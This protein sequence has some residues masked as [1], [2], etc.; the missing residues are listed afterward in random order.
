VSDYIQSLIELLRGGNYEDPTEKIGLLSAALKENG[1]ADSKLMV[2]LLTAQQTPLRLAALGASESRTEPEIFAAIKR[3]TS[4]SDRRVRQKIAE[5]IPNLPIEEFRSHLREF[6]RDKESV[7]RL[8]AIRSTSGIFEFI[9]LQKKALIDDPRYDVRMAAAEAL[10]EQEPGEVLLPFLTVVASDSDE[11]VQKKCAEWIEQKL[12]QGLGLEQVAI[13]DTSIPIKAERA[14]KAI[15]SDQFPKLTSYLLTRTETH[16]NPS[17]LARF[18]TDLTS[19]AEKALLPRGFCIQETTQ[20]LLKL[21]KSDSARS[22]ALLGETGTGKSAA[23]NELVYELKKAENGG[24]RVLR[25]SPSE[26]LADTKWL[27]E[28]QTKLRDLINLV[29]KPRHVLIYI[30]NISELSFIGRTS[31]DESNIAT[32]LAPYMEDGSILLLGESTPEEFQRGLGSEGSLHRLF[33]KLV[34]TEASLTQTRSILEEI[35]KETGCNISDAGLDQTLELS[36]QFFGNIRRPGSAAG[37]LRALAG[38]HQRKIRPIELRDILDAIS[39]STGL[40]TDLLDDSLPIDL[41]KVRSFFEKRVMGQPEAVDAV[42]DLVVLIKAGLTDPNKPMGVLLFAGPT[43]VGKTELARALAE[44]IFGDASRLRRFDMS[45]FA[46]REGLERLIGTSMTNG[47]L[48]DAVRQ[49]PFSVVLFDEIEKSNINVFDL[50]LQI[51]D[52][53]RLTDGHG[54][55]VDFRRTVVILTSNIGS[56]PAMF[57][58]PGFNTAPELSSPEPDS[59]RTLRELFR[60]FRPEFLNRIDRI[61]NFRPLSLEVAENIARRE[62]NAVLQRSGLSRRKVAVDVDPSALS[63]LVKEGY[64]PHLGARPLKRAI[65]RFALLPIARVI[66]EGRISEG[67]VLHLYQQGKTL[68][69]KISQEQPKQATPVRIEKDNSLVQISTELIEQ[70][71]ELDRQ[72]RPLGE[73]KSFLLSETH[74]PGFYKDPKTRKQVFD[75]IHKLD[76][77]LAVYDSFQSELTGL[78]HHLLTSSLSKTNMPRIREHLEQLAK[79]LSQIQM[80]SGSRNAQDLSDVL[81]CLNFVDRVGDSQ[82]AV[83]KMSQMYLSYAERLRLESEVLAEQF[84]PQEDRA[85]IQVCGLGAGV[86]MKREAGLHQFEYRFR[87][88]AARNSTEK[89]N[90]Y[91]EIVRVDVIPISGEP[92]VGFVREVTT[93]IHTIKPARSRLVN[94]P[95]WQISTFHAPSVRSLHAWVGGEKAEALDRMHKILFSQVNA[96][97]NPDCAKIVRSYHFGIAPRVKDHVTEKTTSKTDQILKGHIDILTP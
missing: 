61:I 85:Y 34:V 93:K 87:E 41:A 11:D 97:I 73:R 83:Q 15:G 31:N 2:S 63:F 90:N 42:L 21:L 75:E 27:G 89:T 3:I 54:R 79:Q 71:A 30:P 29:R 35:R 46:A 55:T 25:I 88:K 45:E 23:V 9:D 67:A 10:E 22:V 57:P 56:R 38:N 36:V 77:F 8:T 26:F 65:E 50:C 81:L 19:L 39:K 4:D 86:L 91:R 32:A 74:A 47:M 82:N 96:S 49:F 33:E 24:W 44:Y 94:K 6:A 48:T 13:P 70:L 37:L 5:I 69:V 64:S 12:G 17:E 52:A 92:D 60:F 68:E 66:A 1:G 59:E 80:I 18:G 43:G 40:P 16:V 78:H 95:K 84:G 53:G 72:V 62:V 20:T 58:P 76:Q 14:L 7:V 51:F 28:W